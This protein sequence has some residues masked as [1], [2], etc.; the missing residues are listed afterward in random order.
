VSATSRTL[1]NS[2]KPNG[3]GIVPV[4]KHQ[5]ECA[6]N[7]KEENPDTEHCI[8]FH[9]F[10]D[11]IITV[12]DVLSRT[13]DRLTDLVDV[14]V[15]LQDIVGEYLLKPGDLNHPTFYLTD[16]IDHAVQLIVQLFVF[17]L[18]HLS[19]FVGQLRLL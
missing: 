17:Q 5:W 6:N 19:V 18:E 4:E 10:S 1:W 16:F 3:L 7:K 2:D 14:P 8:V 13:D 15:L 12:F 11:L 9:G